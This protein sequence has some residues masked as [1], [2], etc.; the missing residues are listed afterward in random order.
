MINKISDQFFGNYR[1][2]VKAHGQ[3]GLCKIFF[4]GIYDSTLEN[5]T[6]SLPWAEPAQPLFAG[7]A[8]GNGVFQYPD[9][10]S[11][12]WAFFEAGNINRPVFFALTNNNKTN[13]IVGQNSIQ[14]NN[15]IIKFDSNNN[16]NIS[17]SGPITINGAK[18]SING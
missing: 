15:V 7:G 8:S 4:P 5:N 9:I 2:I 3:N 12:I 16:L 6:N 14:Y 17:S 18:V 13:F 10:N 11:V 1:G